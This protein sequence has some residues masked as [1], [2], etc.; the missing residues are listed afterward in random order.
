MGDG[1]SGAEEVPFL[2]RM[3][4]PKGEVGRKQG[5]LGGSSGEVGDKAETERLPPQADFSSAMNVAPPAAPA[6]AQDS[7]AKVSALVAMGFNQAEAELGLYRRVGA[8]LMLLLPCC[9]LLSEDEWRK[10]GKC[11][12]SI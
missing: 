2:E 7:S 10:C 9:L 1:V 11:K 8:M 12:F 5:M 4:S 3:K 6:Q